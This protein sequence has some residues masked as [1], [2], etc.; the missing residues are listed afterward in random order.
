MNISSQLQRFSEHPNDYND[1]LAEVLTPI[2]CFR[3]YLLGPR[4]KEAFEHDLSS[5]DASELHGEQRQLSSIRDR[6]AS[7]ASVQLNDLLTNVHGGPCIVNHHRP[8]G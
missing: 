2:A 6:A 4:L 7:T 3:S 8:V 1:S 5:A